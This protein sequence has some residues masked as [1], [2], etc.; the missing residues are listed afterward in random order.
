MLNIGKEYRH[1]NKPYTAKITQ[2]NDTHVMCR[3]MQDQK[4]L[5]QGESPILQRGI[6]L[7]K[8]YFEERYQ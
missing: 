1:K 8:E 3:V 5:N 4:T 7:R 2:L 6:W